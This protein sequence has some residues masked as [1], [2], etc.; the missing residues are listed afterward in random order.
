MRLPTDLLAKARAWADADPDV[1]SRAELE[2]LIAEANEAEL[3]DRFAMRLEFGTAGLRGV[4]GA[5]PNRMNRAVVIMTSYGLGQWLKARMTPEALANGV[6]VGHDARRMS[7]AFAEDTAAVLAAMGIRAHLFDTCQPT[8]LVAFA[9][10]ELGAAAAVVVTASHNPPEYNGY[11]LYGPTASQIVSPIDQEVESLIEKAPAPNAIARMD[12][13]EARRLGLVRDVPS[14]VERAYLDRVRELAPG[15]SPRDFSIVYTPLHGVGGALTTKALAE[16]GFGRVFPVA[17]QMTPDGRFPTVAFPNPE[18]KGAMDLALALAKQESAE[19]V[20][21]NDPDADRL[22]VAVRGGDGEYVQLTGNQVGVLLGHHLLTRAKA[23]GLPMG[24]QLVITTVVSTPML[25]VM[26]AR[27]GARY[28][29]TL[30]GFKWIAAR[31]LALAASDQTRFVF[32]F[33]EALG[34]TVGTL[35]RDKD[36]VA[37]ATVF[38]DMVAELRAQGRSVLDQ[39]DALAREYGLFVSEQVNVTKKGADGAAAIK[40]IM[41]GLR[42]K[43]PSRLGPF[44]LTALRD[45]EAKTR[46]DQSSGTVTPLTLPASN[47]LTFELEGG[48]RVIA[49]PS[50]TKPKIKFYF[51]VC[52]TV[53]PGEAIDAARSRAKAT[54]TAVRDDFIRAVS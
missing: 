28:D 53:R 11:K 6:V 4:I 49:R 36:G 3:A 35:V 17:E 10:A 18:E 25:S 38:A 2:A 52:E 44:G 7:R 29:E 8:P 13:G 46:T 27:F 43:A 22:A 51:D 54:L 20:L 14:A 9:A 50:G 19:L 41:T 23:A 45:Y 16:A 47:V 24:A 31:A 30:T 5:G 48:S 21:A 15:T 32:G 1:E 33:E 39:L 37:A 42:K 26:A 40:A 12:L 34:Y